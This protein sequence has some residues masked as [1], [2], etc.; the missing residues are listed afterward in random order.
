MEMPKLLEL[1]AGTGSVGKVF[2]A[3]GWE[4][5]SL[6]SVQTFQPTIC[7]DILK[8]DYKIYPPGHFDFV[9]SSPPCTEFSRALTSRPRNLEVGD[10]LV[11]KTL[12]IL[13]YFRPRWW[14][15]ENPHTGLMKT[16]PMMQHMKAFMRRVCYC[17]YCPEDDDSWAYRKDTAIWTNLDT[18][19]P[20]HMCTK[21][22]PCRWLEGSSTHPRTAQRGWGGGNNARNKRTQ[23][24]LYS[25]PPSLMEEWLD[26]VTEASASTE[27]LGWTRE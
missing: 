8:W 15:I 9:H 12:E 4:V 7:A 2:E 26:A 13:T 19:T 17:V 6:D 11:D 3:A 5:V 22:T 18:W 20:R 10:A 21:A 25:M 23:S 24:Q 1:F 14:T 16:R 27:A